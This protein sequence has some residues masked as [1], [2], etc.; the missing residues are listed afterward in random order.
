V[1]VLH[2]PAG[3]GVSV[4]TP[5]IV[6][7]NYLLIQNIIGK[8]SVLGPLWSLP[9]EVQMYLVLPALYFLTLRRRAVT[10]LSCL[11][12]FS[13]CLGFLI[14]WLSGGHLN[15]AAYVPCFLSGVLCYS[16]RDRIRAFVP[17]AFWA[18][19]VVL[20]ISGYCI[21][22]MRVGARFWYGW[23]FCF[24]L[25]LAINI[26]H[27]STQKHL[28]LAAEKIALY[29]YGVYL[30][31]APVLYLV[32]KVLGIKNLFF[33]PLLFLVL[34]IV[35]SV[36]TYHFIESPFI[37]LGKRLSSGKV[38]TSAPLPVPATQ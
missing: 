34:T 24:V 20:M 14:S 3:E 15:M 21:A 27:A 32:F 37:E 12:A 25:G 11:L 23:I 2:I 16:L 22:T 19:A 26:F 1:L 18:P 33:G 4:I 5:R 36:I 38:R 30:I 29:S 8:A 35:G 9:Y 13:C 28:N 31:N 6:I 10:W 7:S 17:A